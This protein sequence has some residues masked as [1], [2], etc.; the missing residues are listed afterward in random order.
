MNL[1]YRYGKSYW[2]TATLTVNAGISE[3]ENGST[4]Y[5]KVAKAIAGMHGQRLRPIL[6]NQ[7]LIY[8]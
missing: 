1:C 5:E 3:E 4:N 6:I 7:T 2:D 8:A